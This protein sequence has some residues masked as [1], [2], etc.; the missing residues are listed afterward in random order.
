MYNVVEVIVAKG[1][2]KPD[3]VFAARLMAEA[4]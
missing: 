3:Q 2:L 4:R 1:R